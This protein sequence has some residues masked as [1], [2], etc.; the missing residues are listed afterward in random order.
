MLHYFVDTSSKCYKA[1]HKQIEVLVQLKLGKRPISTF[2]LNSEAR[3]IAVCSQLRPLPEF[4]ESGSEA[5]LRPPP[6]LHSPV[7]PSQT[8]LSAS[9]WFVFYI[10]PQYLVGAIKMC[11]KPG[12]CLENISLSRLRHRGRIINGGFSFSLPL[13]LFCC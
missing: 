8:L 11:Q 10:K 5:S 2:S 1:L 4:R 9:C 7:V 6:S 12:K 3:A 13:M